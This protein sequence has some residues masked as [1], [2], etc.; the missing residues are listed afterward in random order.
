[1]MGRDHDLM[2]RDTGNKEHVVVFQKGKAQVQ[3][4]LPSLIRDLIF[5]CFTF[6]SHLLRC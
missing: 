2:G 5:L 6:L 1:M 3:I 4:L